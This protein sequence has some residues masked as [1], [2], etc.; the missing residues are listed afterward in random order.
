MVSCSAAV[1]LHADM[2]LGF[3]LVDQAVDLHAIEAGD[4]PHLAVS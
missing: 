2:P 4:L 1:P 3:Q